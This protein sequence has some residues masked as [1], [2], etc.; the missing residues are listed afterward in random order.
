MLCNDYKR[1][2]KN[3]LNKT[4]K[5]FIL[6]V[7]ALTVLAHVAFKTTCSMWPELTHCTLWPWTP[8]FGSILSRHQN[9]CGRHSRCLDLPR[10]KEV[11]KNK[12]Y[13]FLCKFCNQSINQP[14]QPTVL[15]IF[16]IMSQRQLFL[17]QLAS[18]T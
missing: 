7:S 5:T 10:K 17:L 9:G 18:S 8:F 1:H 16:K 15:N 2:A 11:R 3:I 4:K 14:N 13:V 12:R 6:G